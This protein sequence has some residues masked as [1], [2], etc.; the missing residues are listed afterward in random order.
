MRIGICDRDQNYVRWITGL[1]RQIDC[2]KD[3]CI[4][5]YCKPSWLIEDVLSG[6][7]AFDLLIISQQ[8]E[9]ISA[10]E[11]VLRIQQVTPQCRAIILAE[12]NTVSPE[13]YQLTQSVLLP[14]EHVPLHLITVVSHLTASLQRQQERYFRL[15]ADREHRII[16][17]SQILY[18]EKVLRKTVVTTKTKAYETYQSPK[19]LLGQGDCAT[20]VQCHRSYYVNLPNIKMLC[21]TYIKLTEAYVIPVGSTFAESVRRAYDDYWKK[22]LSGSVHS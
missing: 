19:E 21:P 22:L 17:C 16:P 4:V 12:E 1:V 9:K 2:V 3:S 15:I 20:F 14:K 5:P 18:M 8:Q 7:E 13:L 11:A 10:V 6:T